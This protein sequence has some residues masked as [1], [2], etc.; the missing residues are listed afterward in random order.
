MSDEH[1]IRK[2]LQHIGKNYDTLD[3]KAQSRLAEIEALFKEKK[4]QLTQG[5]ETIK[6]VDFSMTEVAEKVSFGKTTLYANKTFIEYIKYSIDE[7]KT[8]NPYV[9]IVELQSIIQE[10][11]TMIDKMVTRD[12]AVLEAKQEKNQLA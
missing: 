1:I 8:N 4:Q 11:K 7:L 5:I 12:I 9:T 6:N 3:L 10:Q 2:K